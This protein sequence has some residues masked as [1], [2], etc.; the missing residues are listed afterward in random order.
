MLTF[1]WSPHLPAFGNIRRMSTLWKSYL[2]W[3]PSFL[4]DST[5]WL[6]AGN[7]NRG[8]WGNRYDGTHHKAQIWGDWF[9][10]AI[11][12]T[13]HAKRK[14][15]IQFKPVFVQRKAAQQLNIKTSQI[16]R[17]T[18]KQKPL[19]PS[20]I[21]WSQLFKSTVKTTECIQAAYLCFRIVYC[22]IKRSKKKKKKICGSSCC[23]QCRKKSETPS[24]SQPM[25]R[26]PFGKPPSPKIFTI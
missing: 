22:L 12:N 19:F 15:A 16:F 2:Q 1:P 6:G 18:S 25:G 9:E 21:K 26:D 3:W 17:L 7:P 4:K 24:G 10:D 8:G 14:C 5:D 11:E 23:M 20:A 13:F